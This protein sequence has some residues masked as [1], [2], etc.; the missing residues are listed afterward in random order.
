MRLFG[1]SLS[2][3]AGRSS[4]PCPQDPFPGNPG[5][6]D[7]SQSEAAVV[8]KFWS[9]ASILNGVMSI[10][11]LGYLVNLRMLMSLCFACAGHRDCQTMASSSDDE[12][13]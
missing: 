13:R 5:G 1:P 7:H 6:I 8:N 12:E 10:V 3:P 11:F 9:I 4:L 2:A